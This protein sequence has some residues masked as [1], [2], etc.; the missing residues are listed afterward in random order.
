[1]S[2]DELE[3]T[4]QEIGRIGE[5][6]FSNFC[7]ESRLI[8][9]ESKEDIN[10]WDCI[11][12]DNEHLEKYKNNPTEPLQQKFFIQ[13]KSTSRCSENSIKI[14]LS[15]AHKLANQ[16]NPCFIIVCVVS[17]E[18][19]RPKVSNMYIIHIFDEVL[20]IILKKHTEAKSENKDTNHIDI[21]LSYKK[22]GTEINFQDSNTTLRDVLYKHIGKLG[23][24]YTYKKD[25]Q[26]K[27]L[28]YDFKN[29]PI[30][31]TISIKAKNKEE[32]NE[33]FLGHGSIPSTINSITQTRYG[34]DFTK[35]KLDIEYTFNV[36]PSY[37]NIEIKLKRGY[38]CEGKYVN[39]LKFYSDV[40]CTPLDP[41][42]RRLSNDMFDIDLN[43]DKITFKDMLPDLAS[44]QD[45][46][47]F[48]MIKER[49]FSG[50]Q[51]M[52]TDKKSCNA[53]I[54]FPEKHEDMTENLIKTI[55]IFKNIKSFFDE[56]GG[57]HKFSFEKIEENIK[58]LYPIV[59]LYLSKV[60][61][62]TL[63]ATLEIYDSL[64]LEG[65]TTKTHIASF[66][67]VGEIQ[68][69]IYL[70]GESDNYMIQKDKKLIIKNVVIK[71]IDLIINQDDEKKKFIDEFVKNVDRGLF[72]W[73]E[74]ST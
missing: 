56:F 38:F 62:I 68:L 36:L 32:F 23:N 16:V 4:A 66:I 65:L 27:T 59:Q 18:F 9:N 43:N 29:N 74:M 40:Y 46:L 12:E 3:I 41:K 51:I 20:N 71:N 7:S 42:R 70:V 37:K 57:Q 55:N 48:L 26:L 1:M 24:Q 5:K 58:N 67:D 64:D 28:G 25:H 53:K 49:I 6:T 11:I 39:D 69:G 19:K 31:G 61:D 72:M 50:S 52:W 63:E 45:H 30:K 2:D 33:F 35:E 8:I 14:K 44:M 60:N 54:K 10:G 13:L 73:T 15:A 21:S 34:K 47:Q 17:N 22:H